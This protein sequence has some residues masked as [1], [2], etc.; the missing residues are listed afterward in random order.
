MLLRPPR[1]AKASSGAAT[2]SASRRSATVED[3]VSTR[4][5]C[6][7]SLSALEPVTTPSLPTV[8]S[9]SRRVVDSGKPD[10]KQLCSCALT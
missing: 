1:A 9:M 7:P 8:R 6:Q 2:A 10:R 3:A 5:S 4:S